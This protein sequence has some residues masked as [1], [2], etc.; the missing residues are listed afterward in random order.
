MTNKKNC[1]EMWEDISKYGGDKNDYFV[2]NAIVNIPLFKCY[3]CEEA[4]I[5]TGERNNRCL[6]CPIY[7]G[8]GKFCYDDTEPFQKWHIKKT[9]KNAETFLEFIKENWNEAE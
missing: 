9:K 6:K 8:K 3:A 7:A 1:I 2:R 4:L 5:L